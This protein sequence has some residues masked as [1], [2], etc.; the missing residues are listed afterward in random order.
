MSERARRLHNVFFLA[1]PHDSVDRM[2]PKIRV[3]EIGAPEGATDRSMESAGA[4]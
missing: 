1:I 4:D 2:A 3:R